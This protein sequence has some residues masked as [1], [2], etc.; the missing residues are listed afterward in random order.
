M[1]KPTLSDRAR[2]TPSSPIRKLSHLATNAKKSGFHVYHLNIG[3]PDMSLLRSSSMG[4]RCSSTEGGRL[5]TVTGKREPMHRVV[6][7]YQ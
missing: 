2:N 7:I 5:R 6:E 3:Q 4:C 1:S